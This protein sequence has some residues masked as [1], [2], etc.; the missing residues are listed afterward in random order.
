MAYRL[1]QKMLETIGENIR[2]ERKRQRRDQLQVAVD[3][4]VE[5]SY[6]AKI[7]RGEAAN[8]S[9]AKL[10]AITRALG[11]SSSHILPF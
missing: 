11:V 7:E 2:R 8:P 1:S 9:L 10:Y 4:G 6:F 5:P 3:A